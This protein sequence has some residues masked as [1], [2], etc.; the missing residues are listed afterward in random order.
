MI[1]LIAGRYGRNGWCG[2]LGSCGWCGRCSRCGWR[3]DAWTRQALSSLRLGI[4]ISRGNAW[5]YCIWR[6]S[7]GCYGSSSE[8]DEFRFEGDGALGG[9]GREDDGRAKGFVRIAVY[10]DDLEFIGTSWL[11]DFFDFR[12]FF[13]D[14]C[15]PVASRYGGNAGECEIIERVDR[16]PRCYWRWFRGERTVRPK[17]GVFNQRLF[18]RGVCLDGQKGEGGD[19]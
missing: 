15:D 13:A 1:L 4:W 3:H 19:D 8:G 12:V 10:R 14:D 18:L 11:D 16:F 17:P 2:Q 6:L 9:A 7:Y 5:R